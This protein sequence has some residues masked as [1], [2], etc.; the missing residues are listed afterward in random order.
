MAGIKRRDFLK[1]G[2]MAAVTSGAGLVLG[3]T[4]EPF[5]TAASNRQAQRFERTVP[6][7]REFNG[8][9]REEHLNRLAFPLGGI[10]AGM[11][12]LEGNGCISHVSVR[13]T[14]DVF[15]EPFMFAAISV[16][17][18]PK[19]AKVVEGPLPAWKIFGGPGAG[20]GAGETSY[21]FL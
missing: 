11:V 12:C 18:N 21:G 1:Q 5:T 19:S 6:T 7:V 2:T 8:P 13:N 3:G 9:Y 20:N 17:D 10:G 16:K 15:N 14:P 4:Q